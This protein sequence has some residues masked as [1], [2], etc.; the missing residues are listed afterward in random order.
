MRKVKS[1][2]QSLK[3]TF[4]GQLDGYIRFDSSFFGPA[5]QRKGKP[6]L[7]CS[8]SISSRS[9]RKK[10]GISYFCESNRHRHRHR[11]MT[12][13]QRHT[14]FLRKTLTRL[15]PRPSTFDVSEPTPPRWG[16]TPSTLEQQ[17]HSPFKKHPLRPSQA[18][19]LHL[20]SSAPPILHSLD[21]SYPPP[22]ASHS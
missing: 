16:Y 14:P 11:P 20:Q 21:S 4:W 10:I 9:P 22:T 12:Q 17:S 15:R 5:V 1:K 13:I 19:D 6:P 2:I 8:A 18:M 3:F 7:P